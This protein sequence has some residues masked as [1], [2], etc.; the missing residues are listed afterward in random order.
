[1]HDLDNFT[2]TEV[3]NYLIEKQ[4]QEKGIS[5]ALAK[6][7]IINALTYNVVVEAIEEQIDFLLGEQEIARNDFQRTAQKI[8]YELKAIQPI[9]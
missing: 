7:L 3:M 1:M 9:L 8:W 5:K 4:V 6:K 2:I